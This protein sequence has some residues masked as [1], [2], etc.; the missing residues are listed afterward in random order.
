MRKILLGLLGLVVLLFGIA[1]VRTLMVGGADVAE[2][3]TSPIDVDVQSAAAHLGAAVRFKTLSTQENRDAHRAEF[4]G[5]AAWLTETY[6]NVHRVTELE[7]VSTYTL[8][9]KWAGTDETLDPVLLMSHQDVV[10]VVPGTEQTWEEDPFSGK[11]DNGFVWGRGTID[12]K[13]SLIA[14]L[15]AAEMLSAQGFQPRRTIY[16]AFG[17]DEE[18]G[19]L[20]GSLKVAELFRDRGIRLHWLADE[21]GIV[22]EGLVPGVDR[23]VALVGVAEKGYVTLELTAH[24]VGGHS[25][26]PP[27]ETAVGRLARAIDRLQNTQ[28]VGSI[29]GPAAQMFDAMAPAMSFGQRFA[30]ANRWLLGPVLESI[31]LESPP[32]A[33]M[34]RTTIAPTMLDAGIKEN[35]LPPTASAKVNFRI[36]PRDNVE[37]IVAHV[38]GAV[39]DENVEIT[40]SNPGREPSIVSGT[41]TEGF[42][43]ISRTIL[44]TFP[45][46]IV[47]PNLVVGGTDARHF[48][49]VT[50]NIY[51][52]IP[53]ILGP[54]DRAR[55][56]GTNERVTVENMGQAVQF[57]MR[58]I[59]SATE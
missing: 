47:A 10:P 19:G 2:S 31:L 30:V 26:M 7:R 38:T 41:G 22:S 27:A 21:G 50:D 20:E 14:I 46:A 53:I 28:F 1:L 58:L 59:P 23:P 12:T 13:G 6:P 45:D 15:E 32:S 3:S 5:F 4:D 9:Y 29:D 36:H 39:D 16:F 54:D 18:V 56:H 40:V 44:A 55:F 17:H 48:E 42:E 49:I 43:I 34:M 33:A 51:R 52:F 37:S 35:V 11:V 8:L 57:Y 25:S 24:A